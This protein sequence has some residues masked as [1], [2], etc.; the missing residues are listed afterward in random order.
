MASG[1]ARGRVHMTTTTTAELPNMAPILQVIGWRRHAAL[2]YRVLPWYWTSMLW[3]ID[4]C[5]NKVS[6]D[7]NYYLA[8]AVGPANFHRA[9][10]LSMG[11]NV[12]ICACF[13]I[14]QTGQ[15][16]TM[17]YPLTTMTMEKAKGKNLITIGKIWNDFPYT[18]SYIR[19]VCF[20]RC[21]LF[22]VSSNCLWLSRQ[23][24]NALK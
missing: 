3:S 2:V 13:K 22:N 1:I 10:V 17:F 4:T 20:E 15:M 21:T 16:T 9:P 24:L 6:A 23:P 5:Q 8:S 19:K 7:Q 12:L 11:W 18:Y 14:A